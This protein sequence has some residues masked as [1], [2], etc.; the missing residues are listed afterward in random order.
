MSVAGAR[1]VKTP[2]FEPQAA[3][4]RKADESIDRSTNI[5]GL[6][7]GFAAPAA[8]KLG[9][10]VASI[11]VWNLPPSAYEPSKR[12]RKMKSIV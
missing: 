4:H 7:S 9:R 8:A 6:K 11:A 12:R 3:A 5:P 1:A 10:R 2:R